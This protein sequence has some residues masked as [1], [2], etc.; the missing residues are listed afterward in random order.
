MV[1]DADSTAFEDDDELLLAVGFARARHVVVATAFD[2]PERADDVVVEMCAGLVARGDREV[3]RVAVG[4]ARRTDPE[5][6][7]RFE[8]VTV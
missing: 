5:R 8:F 4:I 6:R 2:D 7:H 3:A 1:I